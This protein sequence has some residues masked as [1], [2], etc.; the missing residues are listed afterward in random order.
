MCVGETKKKMFSMFKRHMRYMD[1]PC[2]CGSAEQMFVTA[3]SLLLQV[4]S[5]QCF[6][7]EIFIL[8]EKRISADNQ[9]T[10]KLH[11]QDRGVS[12]GIYSGFID[13][14]KCGRLCNVH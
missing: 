14:Q 8:Y 6:V 13:S 7:F 11:G 10:K 9:P 12:H 5:K 1:F 2:Q 4:H 3:R